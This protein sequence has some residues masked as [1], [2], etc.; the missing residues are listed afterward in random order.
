MRG[1]AAAQE[2]PRVLRGPTIG[3]GAPVA[4]APVPSAP[5]IAELIIAPSSDNLAKS[6]S[7]AGSHE[8]T[9]AMAK[10]DQLLPQPPVL[11]LP[12]FPCPRRRRSEEEI[13]ERRNKKRPRTRRQLKA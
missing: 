10:Q 6:L 12:Q 11:N 9:E 5:S 1:S 4:L 8:A 2:R 13:R 3:S 7:S